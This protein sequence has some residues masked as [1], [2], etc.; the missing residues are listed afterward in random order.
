MT[1]PDAATLERLGRLA[2]RVA[3]HAADD[4]DAAAALVCEVLGDLPA[5]A[6]EMRSALVYV[7]AGALCAAV[8]EAGGRKS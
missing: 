5:R 4:D 2:E 8:R 6:E 7:G 1:P 3:L